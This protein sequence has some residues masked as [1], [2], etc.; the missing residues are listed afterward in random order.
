MLSFYHKIVLY[1][2]ICYYKYRTIL[3]KILGIL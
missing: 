1:L 3:R 2:P